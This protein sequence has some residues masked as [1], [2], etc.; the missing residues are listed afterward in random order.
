MPTWSIDRAGYYHWDLFEILIGGGQCLLAFL[1]YLL[2]RTLYQCLFE[3]FGGG[4]P[5]EGEHDVAQGFE[6]DY[7]NIKR[8]PEFRQNNEK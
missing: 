1:E 8:G 2:G 5:K 3:V 7:G 6:W 4:V